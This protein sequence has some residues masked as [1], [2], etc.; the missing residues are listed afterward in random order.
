MPRAKLNTS[1]MRSQHAASRREDHLVS[2]C[3]I[4]QHTLMSAYVNITAVSE[5][6]PRDWKTLGSANFP[7]KNS[8]LFSVL[9]KR[10]IL[11]N[12]TSIDPEDGT[13]RETG[14]MCMMVLGGT[15][16]HPISLRYRVRS[17]AIREELGLEPLLLCLEESVEVVHLDAQWAPA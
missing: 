5:T 17:S 9:K 16:A 13:R 6:L 12:S 15:S 11:T 7:S 2:T 14:L 8:V 10:L 4:A 3:D 1:K